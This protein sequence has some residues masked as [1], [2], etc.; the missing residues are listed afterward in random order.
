MGYVVESNLFRLM[1]RG[2]HIGE[3]DAP[4]VPVEVAEHLR[5]AGYAADSVDSYMESA[6]LKKPEVVG[7]TH[8]PLYDAMVAA[9]VY[10]DLTKSAK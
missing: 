7:G 6:G 8:N 9:S 5:I 3:W 10:F 4:Y 2:G 1:V